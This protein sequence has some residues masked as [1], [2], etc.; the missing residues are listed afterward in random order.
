MI[1]IHPTA[2]VSPMADIEDSTRGTRIV[3]GARSVIDSF[4]KV[5]PAVGVGNLVIGYDVVIN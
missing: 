5:K 2:K 1:E 4:V 3:I